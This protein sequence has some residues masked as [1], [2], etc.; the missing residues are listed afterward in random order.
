M[1]SYLIILFRA[2]G[3]MDVVTTAKEGFRKTSP[4][5]N[6]LNKSILPINRS[7]FLFRPPMTLNCSK[8]S[9]S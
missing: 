9:T 6:M 8:E 1:C 3:I 5:K 4:S 7:G 2:G